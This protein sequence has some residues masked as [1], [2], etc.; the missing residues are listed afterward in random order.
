M[1]S[2]VKT[3]GAVTL[4]CSALF[5]A[6][7]AQAAACSATSGQASFIGS[8]T[9]ADVTLGGLDSSQCI[10]SDV[11]PAQGLSGNTSGFDGAFGSGW[12][13]LSKGP[14][15]ATIDGVNFTLTFTQPTGTSGT[16][17]LTTDQNATFDLVFAM[18]ASDHSGAFLFD[19]HTSF[20]ATAQNGSWVIQWLN[21]GGAVPGFSNINFFVRDV[22]VDP[23]PEPA[24]YGLLLAGLLA[25]GFLARRRR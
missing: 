11:N 8:A 9:T 23:V 16:W 1:N 25:G 21:N 7:G 19:D 4:A 3:L 13:L 15:S 6:S 22:V 17:T 14:G 2:T 10:I 12:S 24:T 20:A 5:G 18:H